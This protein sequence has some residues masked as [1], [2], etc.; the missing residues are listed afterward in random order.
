MS[1]VMVVPVDH[2]IR[3]GFEG[4][5]HSGRQE[6]RL[7]HENSEDERRTRIGSLR[8][9]AINA[10]SKFRHSL[11]KRSRRSSRVI[12]VS[13]E[14][15]RDAE[16]LQAVDAFRQTL[17]LEEL[18]PSRHDD[19]HMMLRFLKARKFDIEKTKQ[20]WVDMLQWR[21]EFNADTI[22]EDF[23]FQEINEVLEHYPQ[24][25]HGVDKEGRPVY[26]ELLGKVDPNKLMQVTTMDRYVQYHVKEF[27]RT[28][29]VKFP[30][31]SIAAK[32]HIDQSTT[33]L[34]VQGVGLKNFN[35]SA[36]ELITRLQKIDGDNYPETL[37]RM[38]IINAG[39]GFRML[40]NTVKS[41]IDPKTTAKIHVLGNKYQSKLLEVIDASELPEFL[42][43]TCTCA[44][45]GGCLRSDKGPWKDT[46]ILKMVQNG[47]ARCG[48]QSAAFSEA[49][50]KMI[51][52]D[53]ILYPKGHDSFHLGS[54]LN[55]DD[56][57]SLS[58]KIR[59]ELI[60]HPQLSPVHEQASRDHFL[61]SYGYDDYIPM[62]DKAVD[63]TWMKEV[64]D[65]KSTIS[66]VAY[67][68]PDACKVP[69]GL[70]TQL[71]SGVMAFVMGIIT[72]LRLTRGMPNKIA[73]AAYYMSPDYSSGT[74]V[75]GLAHS[76]PPVVAISGAEYSC[77]MK[78][79]TELEEKV[80][81]LSMKPAEMPIE[82]EE[83]LKTAVSRIGVLEEELMA[84]KKALEE[85]MVRQQELLEY[86]D[87]KKKKKNK[88]NPF[89]W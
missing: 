89:C 53:E 52:E 47:E 48:R 5:S 59:R 19:Y 56:M 76:Q 16:E 75:K 13:I 86:I 12:S 40:W 57:R 83:M 34:D 41:F 80:S 33:I 67:P 63:A 44:D 69:E 37:C 88:L 1:D 30:A 2:I 9:K 46:D 39:P 84:T 42:G 54:I 4:S 51:S 65:E 29:A 11:T 78:R 79:L 25:H 24:G 28:F 71:L 70:S 82:K 87:K 17:I 6:R 74:V 14:D 31:C 26:I 85:A 55:G 3:S 61:S 36:R 38:F 50:E 81:I 7:E 58:P 62:V 35:K 73:N 43:G 21:K 10:S 49:E 18:L 23:E 8:K 77:V 15:V 27:E 20:M 68:L 72:M 66:K 32:R 64:L 45:H 22:M 60:E